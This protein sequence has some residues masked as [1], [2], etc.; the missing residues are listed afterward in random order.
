MGI[1]C[2]GLLFGI[3][4]GMFDA[5]NMPILCQFVGARQRAT[6]YGI[7]NMVGVFAGAAITNVLGKWSDN[8]D[9]GLGFAVLAAV[10]AVALAV[11]LFA[12]RPK[13]DNME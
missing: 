13:T 9:L 12:L 1:I 5:N 6:A 11:Q 10:V 3:G 2:A 4:F 7:M 8:G